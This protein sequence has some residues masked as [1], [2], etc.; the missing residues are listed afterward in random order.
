MVTV[1]NYKYISWLSLSRV[2][3][4]KD[5]R[6]RDRRDR[7]EGRY[8]RYN[9]GVTPSASGAQTPD[10]MPLMRVYN[11]DLAVDRTFNFPARPSPPQIPVDPRRAEVCMWVTNVGQVCGSVDYLDQNVG[12]QGRLVNYVIRYVKRVEWLLVQLES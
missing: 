11:G 9:G 1:I 6:V 2:V 12:Q 3:Q 8:R 7:G 4:N 10:V 5:V